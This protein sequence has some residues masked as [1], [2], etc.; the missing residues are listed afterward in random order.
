VEKSFGAS[1]DA[2]RARMP[3]RQGIGGPPPLN[4]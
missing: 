2:D 4:D 3:D 1:P